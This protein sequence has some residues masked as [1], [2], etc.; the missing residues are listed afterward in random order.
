M[1]AQ[2]RQKLERRIARE[3][4]TAAIRA[5]YA[6][7]VHDGEAY[8]IKRSTNASDIIAAMFSTDQDTLVIR[9]ASGARLGMVWF[10]YGNDGFDVIA[11]Y[12]VSLEAFLT[13][14]HEIARKLEKEYN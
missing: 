3:T 5:G 1:N 14:V 9:D 4:V 11:D 12:S 13:P 10:V 6:V 7:S 8:A 2:T